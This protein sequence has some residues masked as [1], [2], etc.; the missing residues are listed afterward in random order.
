VFGDSGYTGM[1]KRDEFKDVDAA[2]LI[3]EKP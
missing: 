2:F 1:A 3:A